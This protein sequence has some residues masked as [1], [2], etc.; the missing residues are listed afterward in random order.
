MPAA[1]PP[2]ATDLRADVTATPAPPSSAPLPTGLAW[3]GVGATVA[4]GAGAIVT[5]VQASH[6]YDQLRSSCG[7]TAEGCATAD[8]DQVKSRARIA[9]L[10]WA[11]TGVTAAA[12]GIVVIINAREVGFAGAWSF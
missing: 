2:P 12:T 1:A 5:G 11:A 3:A 10:L 4:L 7:H 9:N 8:I 6:R